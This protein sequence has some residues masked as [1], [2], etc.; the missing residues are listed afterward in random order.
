MLYTLTNIA[1]LLV[2]LMHLW[3]MV[4]EMFFWQKP[5]GMKIFHL[6]RERAEQSAALAANQ[7]L[8]NGFL[9][10]GLLWSL[11]PGHPTQA[12]H[13]KLFFLS[14]VTLAGIYAAFTVNRRIFIVQACPALIALALLGFA[15][16]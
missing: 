13:L 3:F 10:A 2:A 16:S 12:L 8:Y 9:S 6:T 15:A 1:V 4:L 11:L 7:G 14:C 5:L